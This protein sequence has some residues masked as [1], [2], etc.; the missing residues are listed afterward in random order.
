MPHRAVRR[1][2]PE[3]VRAP[4]AHTFRVTQTPTRR[5]AATQPAAHKDPER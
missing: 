3:V 4:R 5:Q 2:G 1:E